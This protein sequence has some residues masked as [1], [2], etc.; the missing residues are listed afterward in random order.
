VTSVPVTDSESIAASVFSEFLA[1]SLAVS[2]QSKPLVLHT[3]PR[4]FLDVVTADSPIP[5]LDGPRVEEALVRFTELMSISS[6]GDADPC[7]AGDVA[8]AQVERM[9]EMFQTWATVHHGR[10][11]VS[12]DQDLWREEDISD[13]G[14]VPKGSLLARAR[15]RLSQGARVRAEA[16]D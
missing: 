1:L 4:M 16:N 14:P 2:S 5:D 7:P 10:A 12:Y 3:P 11:S 6:S 8:V 15:R 9:L 13:A